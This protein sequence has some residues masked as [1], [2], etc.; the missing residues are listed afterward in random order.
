MPEPEAVVAIDEHPFMV[1]ANGHADPSRLTA[2][3][4]YCIGGFVGK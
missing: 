4:D 1:T 3:V 2:R